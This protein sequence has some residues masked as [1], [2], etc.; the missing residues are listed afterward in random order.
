MPLLEK[1]VKTGKKELVIIADDVEGEA[2]A[3]LVVNKLRGIFSALAI[4]APGFGDRKKEM[5]ED[6][7]IV[8]GASFISED[9]GKKFEN[10]E[11]SDL[12]HS[13]RVVATKDNTTIIGGKGDKN[14]INNRVSQ[15][16]AQIKKPI[17]ILIKKNFR[18]VWV[19]F[20]AALPLLK[21]ERPRRRLKKN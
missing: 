6:I 13:H 1:L 16:K 17:L 9:L 10:I 21:S 8:T 12:G 5:L 20:R 19:N 15:I 3:T 14:D 7:A 4:K 11:I 2:L 18:S